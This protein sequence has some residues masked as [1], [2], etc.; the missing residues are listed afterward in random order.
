[1]QPFLA[2]LA[3]PLRFSALRLLEVREGQ[4]AH[5]RGAEE[6]QRGSRVP[7]D[8]GFRDRRRRAGLFLDDRD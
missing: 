7:L 3:Q 2:I 1:M 8:L 6:S 5:A 4:P